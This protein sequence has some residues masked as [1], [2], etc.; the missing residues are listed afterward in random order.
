MD[1]VVDFDSFSGLA[2][3]DFVPVFEF[4][5][6]AEVVDHGLSFPSTLCIWKVFPFDEIKFVDFHI[7]VEDFHIL[8]IEFF[9]LIVE[10]FFG[11][12]VKC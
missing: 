6:F 5:D 2:I 10:I 12:G 11:N 7:K 3:G 4:E 8:D 1:F 9:V